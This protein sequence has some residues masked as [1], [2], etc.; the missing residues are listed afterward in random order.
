MLENMHL[1]DTVYENVHL[2]ENAKICDNA[3]NKV[4]IFGLRESQNV[5][6]A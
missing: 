3:Q 4:D 5:K 6:R 2:F 1:F